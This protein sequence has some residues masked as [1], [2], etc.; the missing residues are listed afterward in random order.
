MHYCKPREVRESLP[1]EAQIARCL[2]NSAADGVPGAAPGVPGAAHRVG[3]TCIMVL[4]FLFLVFVV[5][6]N[7]EWQAHRQEYRR[8]SA[9]L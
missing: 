9:V 6:P 8:R 3:S 1:Q 2:G 4:L 7:S 5:Y